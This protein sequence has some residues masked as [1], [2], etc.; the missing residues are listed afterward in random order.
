MALVDIRLVIN[1][2]RQ[3]NLTIVTTPPPAPAVEKALKFDRMPD[4]NE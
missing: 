2:V 3:L 1:D 4:K